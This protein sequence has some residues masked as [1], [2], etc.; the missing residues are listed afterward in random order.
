[1]S[2]STRFYKRVSAPAMGLLTLLFFIPLVFVLGKAFGSAKGFSLEHIRSLLIDSYTWRMVRFSLL[3]AL[4]STV[5]SVL[6][7][8]PGA[9]LLATYRFKGKAL[10]KAITIVPFVLPSILVVL[11]FVIFY[12]N[13]GLLNTLFVRLLNLSEAPLQ[14]LYSFKAIIMA[15]AFY[16]FPIALGLISTFWE[17]MSPTYE[18]SALTLGSTPTQTFLRITLPRLVPSILSA[19]TLI[20]LFCF[21]S[22]AILLVLGGGPQFSNLE[23]EIYRRAKMQGDLNSAAAL[24][25]ISIAIASLLVWIH[26]WAQKKATVEQEQRVFGPPKVQ[27]RP[28]GVLAK[29]L[30]LVYVIASLIFV[31]GPLVAILYRSLGE[32]IS[33][34]GGYAWSLGQY[35]LLFSRTSPLFKAVINSFL[36]ATIAAIMALIGGLG[37]AARIKHSSKKGVGL[38]LF[39]MIP[40]AVSSVV[41]GLGYYLILRFFP[42]TL[43]I[44]FILVVLAHVVIAT[45][46][47][48][49]SILPAY[50][51]MAIRYTQASLTLGANVRQTFIAVELP[52]LKGALATGFAFAFA[53]SVGEIN[54][55]LILSDSHILTIPIMMYRLIG[56][57][58]YAAACALGTLLIGVCIIVF[59]ITE[60]FKR[61]RYE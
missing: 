21:S 31:L 61:S 29:L 47:V 52:L 8:L 38:E 49:R 57:Y 13:N 10:V 9:Y 16:N 4:V 55:T 18:H 28:T 60:S 24:S 36:I 6:V 30:T 26:L 50:R 51:N 2:T 56:S 59:A 45:P 40:M 37:I 39:A 11:G 58:N 34:S 44:Q 23:V 12:G 54:A 33:R 53:L 20:F 43:S 48:L 14:I 19:S 27:R 41:I 25:L 5:V 15:H 17:Q 1:M 42:R 7:A 3:Q 46:F 32:P 35:R 22:F